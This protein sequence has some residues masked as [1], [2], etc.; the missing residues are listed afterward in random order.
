MAHKQE[1]QY[2]V[3][4]SKVKALARYLDAV[5]NTAAG[6]M[7]ELYACGR[8]PSV[9]DQSWKRLGSEICLLLVVLPVRRENLLKVLSNQ[10]NG[11]GRH[12]LHLH[13]TA[14][15]NH[16]FPCE[17]SPVLG[18]FLRHRLCGQYRL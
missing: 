7:L 17:Y 4:G 18:F 14:L 5:V 10:A 11:F 8:C 16:R 12:Q 6:D 9:S 15:M 1:Y 2:Y 13:L 3:A